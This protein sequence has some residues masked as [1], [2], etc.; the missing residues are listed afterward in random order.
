MY[1]SGQ[2]YTIHTCSIFLTH[3]AFSDAYSI[4]WRIQHLLTHT[5]F[6]WRIQHL[7]THTAFSDAYSI[8]WRIQHFLMHTA[9]FLTHTA[10][11]DAYS[12]FW[13]MKHFQ[14]RLHSHTPTP[15]TASLLFIQLSPWRTHLVHFNFRPDVHI[16]FISTFALT[17]TSCSFHSSPWRTHLVHFNLRPDVHTGCSILWHWQP[18]SH[19]LLCH[20]CARLPWPRP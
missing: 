1:G 14:V 2:P 17:Y 4:C 16:L 15:Q 6:F 9:F 5:A 3:A 13:R 10:F 20:H 18:N 11:S 7:L 12:I 8:C 19:G